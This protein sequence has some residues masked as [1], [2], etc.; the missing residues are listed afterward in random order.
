LLVEDEILVI[1]YRNC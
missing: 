1:Y